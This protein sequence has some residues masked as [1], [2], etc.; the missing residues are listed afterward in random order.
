[1]K[2]LYFI[3]SALLLGLGL[4]YSYNTLIIIS[5]I[6]QSLNMYLIGIDYAIGLEVRK[7]QREIDRLKNEIHYRQ[8]QIKQN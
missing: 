1:M 2:Y 5:F 6:F 7:K 8:N 3:I 4:K